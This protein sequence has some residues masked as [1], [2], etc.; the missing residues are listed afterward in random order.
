MK[1]LFVSV[2]TMVIGVFF[3]AAVSQAITIGFDPVGQDVVLGNSASVNLVISGLG[4]NTAPSLGAFDL[5]I[6]YDPTILSLT[7]VGFGNQL[8]I[9]GLGGNPQ[10]VSNVGPGVENIFEISLDL[11][12]DL[13]DFQSGSFTL[14]SLSF[15]TLAYGTSFLNITINDLSDA[16]GDPLNSSTT[17]GSINVTGSTPVPEPATF[18]LVASGLIG[19]GCLRKRKIS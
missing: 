13:E 4:D 17:N 3:I 14:A 15:N 16:W 1:K 5:N 10:G 8:D 9:W 12:S 19:M 7:T 18:L 2:I 11:P 6:S